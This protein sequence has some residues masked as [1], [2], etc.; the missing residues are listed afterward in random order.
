[1]SGSRSNGGSLVLPDKYEL[2]AVDGTSLDKHWFELYNSKYSHS[3]KFSTHMYSWV[4][5]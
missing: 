1:M 3:K 4:V 2:T 5:F